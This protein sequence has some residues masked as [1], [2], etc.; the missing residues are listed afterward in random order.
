MLATDG[1]L[2]KGALTDILIE[3]FYLST[4]IN[5]TT[6]LNFRGTLG[7]SRVKEG[8]LHV[9]HISIPSHEIRLLIGS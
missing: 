5:N 9:L 7:C 6:K 2:S 1:S 4:L 8:T 3:S